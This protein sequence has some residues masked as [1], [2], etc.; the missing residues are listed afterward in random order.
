MRDMHRDQIGF[1]E[2][3]PVA[4]RRRDQQRPPPHRDRLPALH[5]RRV[6]CRDADCAP[7]RRRA[8][9]LAEKVVD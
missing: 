8:A 3:E 4:L 5:L 6:L 2:L 1:R 7:E 9:K